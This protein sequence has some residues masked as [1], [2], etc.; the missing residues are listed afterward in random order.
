MV[1][2]RLRG[3]GV[4]LALV[5]LPLPGALAQG[6]DPGSPAG[7]TRTGDAQSGDAGAGDTV[8]GGPAGVA[9]QVQ[10]DIEKEAGELDRVRRELEKARQERQ[11]IAVR[12]TRILGQ[13]NSLDSEVALKQ[14]LLSGLS[15]KEERLASDLERTRAKLARERQRLDEQR[16]VLRRRLRNIYKYGEKPGLQVLLGAD[17]AVDLVKRFDY[18]LLVAAQDRRLVESIRESVRAVHEAEEGA[19][20][21]QTE[22]RAIRLESEEEKASLQAKRDERGRLLAGVRKEK[23]GRE[24]LIAELEHA[25]K[26]VQQLISELEAKAKLALEGGLPPE[27]TGFR[28]MRGRLPWPVA[29]RVERWFGV[30]KDK[31]FGTSTFNGGI[32][33]RAERESDVVVVHTGRADYVNW[34][35]GYGQCII[36]N[37]GGGYF[38]LYAHTSKVFVSAGDMVHTGQVIASVGDTGS[39][40]GDVLHFEIRK[41]AEPINPAPWMISSPL[42]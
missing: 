37:H 11:K 29:G 22:V 15:R 9:A 20:R 7:D 12:E 39:M 33:I 41:D 14:R 4:A 16:E 32:D 10:A 28:E 38:S 27:G 5:V 8:V 26:Q 24:Q 23:K 3:F 35:P 17:S 18:L 31:R 34:L 21:K 36:V 42:K 2:A 19:A 1:A 6:P 40:L 13:L 25:E 30:Q